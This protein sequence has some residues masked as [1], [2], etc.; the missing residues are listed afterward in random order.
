M[1]PLGTKIL[2]V[3][4]VKGIRVWLTKSL[5]KLGYTNIVE[6][7]NGKEAWE[8]IKDNPIELLFTDLSMPEKTGLELIKDLQSAD[9][10]KS[11][12]VIV[13]TAESDKD[14]IVKVLNSGVDSYIIKPASLPVLEKKLE[15]V[16]KGI[17]G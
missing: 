5:Q 12:K 15:S 1:F 8:Y 11:M 6:A 9:K 7:S 4:D 3:D 16:Y 2:V 13:M 14:M 17:K 10:L